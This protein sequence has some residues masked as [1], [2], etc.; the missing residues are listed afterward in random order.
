MSEQEL[1]QLRDV[2]ECGS[3]EAYLLRVKNENKPREVSQ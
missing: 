3:Y 2:A 1:K